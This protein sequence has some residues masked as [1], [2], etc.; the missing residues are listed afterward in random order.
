MSNQPGSA[1]IIEKPSE[2]FRCQQIHGSGPGV[3]GNPFGKER[4]I[5]HS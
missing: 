3:E 2:S 4:T 5:C 1:S